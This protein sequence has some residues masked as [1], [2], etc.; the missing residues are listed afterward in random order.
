MGPFIGPFVD[1]ETTN[2]IFWAHENCAAYCPE[3]SQDDDGQWYNVTRAMRRGRKLNCAHCQKRGATVGCLWTSCRKSYHGRCAALYTGWDFERADQGKHFYC[4]THR[5]AVLSV[6]RNKNGL[7][8]SLA[9][10]KRGGGLAIGE[11]AA[12]ASA[13]AIPSH[14]QW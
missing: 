10:R 14:T 2:G 9:K 5:T 13:T 7:S 1:S 3:V 6:A 12:I 8:S 11:T 4:E